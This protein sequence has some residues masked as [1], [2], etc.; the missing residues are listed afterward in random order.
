MDGVKGNPIR[1]NGLGVGGHEA[2]NASCTDTTGAPCAC[3]PGPAGNPCPRA[4]AVH[5]LHQEVCR[6]VPLVCVHQA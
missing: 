5:L 6:E 2:L 3:D 1:I 4:A